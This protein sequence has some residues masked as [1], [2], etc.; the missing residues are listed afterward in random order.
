MT[1]TK[2][3]GLAAIQ[4]GAQPASS[5]DNELTWR[6]QSGFL[7]VHILSL[8]DQIRCLLLCP[9]DSLVQLAIER[10]TFYDSGAD[11]CEFTNDFKLLVK[12]F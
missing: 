10:E 5:V 7:F 6:A 11:V 9:F 2:N 1:G 12:I 3:P 4:A 8:T